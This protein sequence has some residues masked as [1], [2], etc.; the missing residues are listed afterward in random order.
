MWT[1]PIVLPHFEDQSVTDKTTITYAI[2]VRRLVNDVPDQE[3]E[4][5]GYGLMDELL[6]DIDDRISLLGWDEMEVAAP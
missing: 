4:F 1:P 6:G 2:R 5:S 3:F